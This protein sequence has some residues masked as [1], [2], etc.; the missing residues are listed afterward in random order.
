MPRSGPGRSRS[1][2][3]SRSAT[4][5]D[6]SSR[7]TACRSS[8]AC[9][10]LRFTSSCRIG[11]RSR[12]ALRRARERGRGHR[13]ARSAARSDRPVV[14]VESDARP[15]RRPAR[16]DHPGDLPSAGAGCAGSCAP[17]ARR[18]RRPPARVDDPARRHRRG[19]AHRSRHDRR[20]G[21]LRGSPARDHR[22][23]DDRAAPGSARRRRFCARVGLLLIR[24][25][26]PH[27]D[28]ARNQPGR[29]GG[30]VPSHLPGAGHHAT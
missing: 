11:G 25:E 10:T 29:R 17:E 21:P 26:R 2:R 22:R 5:S 27:T 30:S 16:S 18:S 13:R 28:N 1:S 15:A 9:S 23:D 3:S 7:W 14:R 24:H 6:C 20:G 19:A 12:P 8:F 4:S